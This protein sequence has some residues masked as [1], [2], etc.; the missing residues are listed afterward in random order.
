VPL[1]PHYERPA[2]CAAFVGTFNS[3]FCPQSYFEVSTEAACKSLAPIGGKSYGGSVNV[4]SFPPGCFWLN[5]GGRVYFN[6]HATG[7]ANANAQQLC[8]GAPARPRR[9]RL[10]APVRKAR[11][12]PCAHTHT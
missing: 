9:R 7:A 1:C 5:V 2:L 4:T 8:A 10:R 12:H 3:K 11:R 6:T